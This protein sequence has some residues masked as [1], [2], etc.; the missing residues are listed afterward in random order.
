MLR[1]TIVGGGDT[2]SL[3]AAS[4]RPQRNAA[5]NVFWNSSRQGQILASMRPQRNAAENAEFPRGAQGA[6][7]ASMRPQR[8]AAENRWARRAYPTSSTSFN[9]A[10]A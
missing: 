2:Y 3:A 9:E 8:N 4:M 5:E 7:E 1:K 6:V 10:A